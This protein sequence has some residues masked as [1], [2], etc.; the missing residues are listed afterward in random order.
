ME[1]NPSPVSCKHLTH[2]AAR[3]R[4]AGK[5][6]HR[7]YPVDDDAGDLIK[8]SGESCQTCT[9]ELI[10]DCVAV[11]CCPCAV[12]NFLAL[13]L[14]K[15]PWMMGRRCLGLGK[16]KGRRLEKERKCERSYSDCVMESDQIS[17]KER[18]VDEWT[19]EN[20]SSGFGNEEQK[21]NF[22]ARFEAEKVWLELYQV[23]HLGFGRLSF[24]GIPS[25]GKG[26]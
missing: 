25:Q 22:S 9:A 21:D 20:L 10:A 17:R 16:K 1:E 18:V 19:L 6:S 8:C 5:K 3:A 2:E 24:T 15:F 13:A 23:D 7:Q 4:P 26:N 14:V 12:V 11:C